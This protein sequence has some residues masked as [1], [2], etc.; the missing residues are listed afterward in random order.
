MGG[1][2]PSCDSLAL[3][4]RCARLSLRGTGT[5]VD[6]ALCSECGTV[7]IP[8]TEFEEVSERLQAWHKERY[9]EEQTRLD[10]FK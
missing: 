1:R 9:P 7:Y 4:E 5:P 10:T 6:A 3:G 2:C 8:E